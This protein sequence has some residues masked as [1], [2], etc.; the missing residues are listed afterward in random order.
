M[1]IASPAQGAYAEGLAFLAKRDHLPEAEMAFR[2]GLAAQPDHPGCLLQLGI[3]LRV[4]GRLRE[5]L[6][7]LGRAREV[8]PADP[9]VPMQI[10]RALRL[11]KKWDA[12]LLAYDAALAADPHH[13]HSRIQ[14]ANTLQEMNRWSEA[15]ASYDDALASL[16][17]ELTTAHDLPGRRAA[18]KE[19]LDRIAGYGIDPAL[20]PQKLAAA[21]Y[22]QAN[23]LV[24]EGAVET[25]SCLYEEAALQNPD[26][27]DPEFQIGATVAVQM[28]RRPVG[29]YVSC[30]WIEDSLHFHEYKLGFCCTSHTVDKGWAN[31]GTF[32]GGPV[33]I[34]FV[35]ARK[36]QLTEENQTGTENACKGCPELAR[37]A[38]P[39]KPWPFGIL[40]INSH[41]ACNQK[42][43]YCFLAIADFEMPAYYYMAEPGIDS[44]VEGGWLAPNAYVLWG[45]G[46]PTVSREF[47]T[48]SQ[49]L[50]ARGCHFNIYS[51]ATRVMPV[52]EE[53]LAQG[54]CHFVTSVDAGTPETYHRIKYLSD[55]PVLL[56]GRTAFDQVWANIAT[57]AKAN[58]D[59]VIVKYIFNRKNLSDPDIEGFI[60]QCLNHGVTR[61]MLVAE[62]TDVFGGAVPAEIWAALVKARTLAHANGLKV[63]FNPLYF[64]AGNMPAELREAMLGADHEQAFK[65][66]PADPATRT[67]SLQD[68]LDL[69]RI[70]VVPPP[71]DFPCGVPEPSRGGQDG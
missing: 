68:Y 40:I 63:H 55:H 19:R 18:V 51:N 13:A 59:S 17:E 50:F 52:L 67:W 36:Q 23:Q 1:T 30:P 7:V 60:K 57:Y 15:L 29:A 47:P 32:Q 61:V 49:K 71:G 21:L 70:I 25:A 11:Q 33:P 28:A 10:G 41:S 53:A 27:S 14:R 69:L 56:D 43:D 4:Q 12:A 38:W 39:A 24:L 16:P 2:A 37:R 64:Q 31:V 34:D 66:D 46:E 3:T 62:F 6:H 26:Y 20:P 22:R 8:A 42:C 9:I 5:A 58:S 48:I 35:L 65:D 44:L 45:G 54:R